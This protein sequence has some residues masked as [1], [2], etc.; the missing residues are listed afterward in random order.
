MTN[1]LWGGRFRK[2]TAGLME[3]F[4]TSLPFDYRLYR[5]DIQAGIAH[6]RVLKEGGYLTAGERDRIISALKEIESEIT[7][8]KVSI[9]SGYEDIHS[10]VLDRLAKKEPALAARLHAGRSRNDLVVLDTRLY[11]KEELDKISAGIRD[12]QGVLVGKGEEYFDLVIP[13]YTH[14]QPAQPVLAAHHLLAYV[15][16]M[17]RDRGRLG[18]AGKRM[19]FLPA[20]SA[21][22]AG[23]DL[24]LDQA[25]LAKLLGFKGVAPNSIDTVADRDFVVEVLAALAICGM[26]LSRL[27]S[28]LVLWSTAEFR[29]IELD[30]AF[31]T[32]SSFLPQKKN[33][34]PAEL[35]RGK[36]GRLYG[37]FQ[38]VLTA[39]HGLP[40]AY[41]RDLQEDKEPL[42]D[43]L[44]T[45]KSSLAVMTGLIRSLKF[46][47]DVLVRA[48]ERGFAC[49]PDL[50]EHLVERGVP[51]REAHR[52]VG[53]L[54]VWVV[55]KGK[56]PESLTLKELKTFSSG[57]GSEALELLT[58]AASVRAKKTIGSTHPTRV[59]RNLAKWK[60]KLKL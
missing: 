34:D 53:K 14:L 2:E 3:R 48:L 44:D 10:L 36:A 7:V 35:V 56:F 60:R 13:G 37:N 25:I 16:M 55:E 54:V 11:L 51:F 17:E 19:N 57:F 45:V 33:P 23:S 12:L 43:S 5:A 22:L 8:G 24:R 6:A 4:G 29:F 30:E 31:C 52:A 38:A 58:P 28:E 41:N 1:K 47:R 49:A 20:G 39:L 32:G 59:K 50:A 21:A 15:E 46:N 26:H 18:D 40:L 42:F 27:A 9:A